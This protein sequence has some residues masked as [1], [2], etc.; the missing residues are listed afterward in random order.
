LEAWKVS[1]PGDSVSRVVGGGGGAA[2]AT[3]AHQ[4]FVSL[5]KYF[6]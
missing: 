4:S 5:K 3:A 6:R 2:A 1:R